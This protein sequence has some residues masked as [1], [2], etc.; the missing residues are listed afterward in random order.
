MTVKKRFGISFLILFLT[1]FSCG[2]IRQ[3]IAL[4]YVHKAEEILAQGGDTLAALRLYDR[5][6]ELDPLE[7]MWFYNR[8]VI[9]EY[10][11]DSIGGLEDFRR[12]IEIDPTFALGHWGTALALFDREKYLKTLHHL[13]KVLFFAPGSWRTYYALG[14]T[15]YR[16]REFE[17]AILNFRKYDAVNQD[18]EWVNYHLGVSYK[19]LG[20]MEKARHYL[21]RAAEQGLQEAKE[22]LE[23]WENVVR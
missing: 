2:R 16:L 19:G 15:H 1:M 13:N 9:R 5:A 21:T 23:R 3:E 18:A 12:S 6:I 7:P 22:E 8:G 11:G 14:L 20:N 17:E 4:A 10:I